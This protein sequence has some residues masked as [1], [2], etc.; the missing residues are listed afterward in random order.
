MKKHS[1]LLIFILMFSFVLFGCHS[2]KYETE[3]VAPTCEEAG[4]TIYTCECGK[5]Y[6]A[7]EV[8]ATGH[9]YETEVVAP[10]CEEAGYTVYTCECGDTYNA[11]EVPAIGH[12]YETEVVE[13][14][15]TE[16]GY[17]VY[18]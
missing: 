11:D 14:T 8:P 7:D 12:K 10:T 17:T 5:T 15:C 4:Y 1:L 2:H 16:E 9:H 18:T 13:P 6:T 3:V